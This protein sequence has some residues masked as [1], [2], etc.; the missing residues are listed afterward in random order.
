MGLLQTLSF[1]SLSVLFVLIF[2]GGYVSSSGVGLSCPN[3]PL[4]PQGFVPGPDFIIE[5][6]H[7]TVAATSGVLVIITMV[8]TLRSRI[9]PRAMKMTSAIAGGAVIGQISLGGVVIVERLHSLLVTGHLGLGLVLF[10]MMLMTFL[11]ARRLE[12]E[13]KAIPTKAR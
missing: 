8:F 4:C 6:F 10:S 12:L 3:W 9:A 11:Y 5:Y 7:R 2:I 1:S 13:K